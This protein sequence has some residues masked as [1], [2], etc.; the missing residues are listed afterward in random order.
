MD[1]KKIKKKSLV[2]EVETSDTVKDIDIINKYTLEKLNE[3]DV[4]TYKVKLCDNE[5]DRVFDKMSD[6][7]LEAFKEKASNL[8]GITDHDWSSNNQVS[9]LYDTEIVVDDTKKNSI[10]EPYKY[11]VGKAYTLKKFEDYVNKISAGLLKECSV[12]FESVEDHCSICGAL[13]TK[14]DDN[15]A[16]CPNGH[17]MGQI[18][19]DKLAYNSIDSLNDVFEWSLVAV[20]CQ[21]DSGIIKKNLSKGA[22]KMKKRT[23]LFKKLFKSKAFETDEN[24][25][26]ADEIIKESE[27][28]DEITEEDINKLIDENH[29]LISEN[30]DLKAK[31]KS[32][33]EA[34]ECDAKT[35]IVEK[36]VDN[37]EP[38]TPTVKENIMKEL[39]IDSLSYVDGQIP[40]IDEVFKPIADKYKGLFKEK[41]TDKS[42]EAKTKEVK[43]DD[44]KAKIN[45]S[46]ISFSISNK[47]A[48]VVK[49]KASGISFSH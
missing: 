12:S 13:T 19:D 46:A 45:K 36:Y 38:L 48:N 39:D 15:V 14:G 7:F 24:K 42:I 28:D 30:D 21:R 31:V 37:M 9:R 2:N 22:S 18:Y 5:V 25:E 23:F 32:L 10:G 3:N 16:V 6:K 40:N 8:T 29:R 41:S 27:S 34:K 47:D 1:V 17:V 4:F 44:V 49:K 20:P 26:L 33:E 11:V 43:T 35:A